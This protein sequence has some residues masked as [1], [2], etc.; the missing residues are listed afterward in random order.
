MCKVI[1]KFLVPDWMTHPVVFDKINLLFGSWPFFVMD[2]VKAETQRQIIVITVI[3][4]F[5]YNRYNH[6]LPEKHHK[7]KTINGETF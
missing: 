5:C 3:T 6:I 1:K 7:G 4:T 2:L